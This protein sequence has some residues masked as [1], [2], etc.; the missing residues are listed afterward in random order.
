MAVYVTYAIL[1]VSHSFIYPGDEGARWPSLLPRGGTELYEEEEVQGESMAKT[2]D[3]GQGNGPD[4]RR[5]GGGSLE[6]ES[7]TA[8]SKRRRILRQAKEDWER[9]FNTV[10]DL[11]AILDDQHRVVHPTAP[12]RSV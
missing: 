5:L 1:T 6:R 11:V 3:A 7:E 4:L 8:A 12:W 2:S 9:T 10:P